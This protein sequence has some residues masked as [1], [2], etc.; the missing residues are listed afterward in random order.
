MIL[1]ITRDD[2][3]QTSFLDYDSE[4]YQKWRKLDAAVDKI[5]KLNGK[6]TIV[7]GSQQY[8]AKGGK[9]RAGV[10]A[11][12]IKRDLI[13]PYYTTRWSDIIDVE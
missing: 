4:R 2:S 5:N 12:A 13:S 6:E 1:D 11:S 10:F 7:L 3:I 8:T 9:G